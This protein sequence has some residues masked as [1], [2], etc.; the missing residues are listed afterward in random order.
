M[1]FMTPPRTKCAL[2]GEAQDIALSAVYEAVAIL[3]H[4]HYKCLTELVHIEAL[5]FL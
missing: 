4:Y 2:I 3:E 5:Q 1:H